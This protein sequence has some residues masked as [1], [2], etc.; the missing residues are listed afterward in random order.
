[1][2]F[3]ADF[4][5]SDG[6]PRAVTL[7][8]MG[9]RFGLL[10][11]R[12]PRDTAG[13]SDA[14]L[15]VL[16]G[17]PLP[18]PVPAGPAGPAVVSPHFP[19]L[20]EMVPGSLAWLLSGRLV[21]DDLMLWPAGRI[22]VEPAFG[23]EHGDIFERHRRLSRCARNSLA[24]TPV[25]AGPAVRARPRWWLEGFP[26]R[27]GFVGGLGLGGINWGSPRFPGRV[28]WCDLRV[29]T[30]RDALCVVRYFVR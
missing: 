22:G 26:A 1:M 11:T 13:W 7:T 3:A 10:M 4:V 21:R 14:T 29:L 15:P 17:V 6:A 25:E 23:S 2:S 18:P 8:C 12:V 16:D 19:E 20:R 5:R 28:V 24:C 30:C 9:I 27:H